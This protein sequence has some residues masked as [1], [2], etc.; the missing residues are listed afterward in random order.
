MDKYNIACKSVIH[1][2]A[3]KA[4]EN[5]AY[6][7]NGV[8]KVV[9]IEANPSLIG[10]LQSIV[11]ED[12]VLQ[13]VVS[14]VDDQECT[15]NFAT[16]TQ[17]S[18]ILKMDLH[19][20]F[21][22]RVKVEDTLAV[23]TITLQKLFMENDLLID[24]FDMINVDIQ[25]ADLFALKGLGDSISSLKVIYTE[26]NTKPMYEDCP[27]LDEMDEYLAKYNFKR[28]ETVMWKDHPWGDAIF[29][30]CE[31]DKVEHE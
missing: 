7:E 10:D 8:E 17:S 27:L 21:F 11:G 1:V 13:A 18:S 14:D 29:I 31:Q 24:D 2:G 9:W 28:V 26:I 23:R 12:L 6:R 22:P 15:F 16:S 3:H 4:E 5:Q 19:R 30:K 25:G 20:K